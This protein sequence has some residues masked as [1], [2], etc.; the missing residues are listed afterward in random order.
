MTRVGAPHVARGNAQRGF[1]VVEAL[2]AL[3]IIA[4][5]TAALVFTVAAD[6][7]ARLMV[8]ERRAAL[9]LAQ[10]QL[11]RARGGEINI[12]DGQWGNLSWHIDREAYG[13]AAA[14]AH[15]RLEQVTVTVSDADHHQLVRLASVRLTS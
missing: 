2:I 7:H 5:M 1:S 9:M 12:D 15:N 6:A 3:A 10:S 8:R 4:A 11:D 13:G 14:F